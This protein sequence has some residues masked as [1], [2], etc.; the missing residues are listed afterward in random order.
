[1][2]SM[3]PATTI[4]A[5]PALIRSAPRLTALRA[6]P[7]TLLMLSAGTWGGNPALKAACRAGIC[8]SPA[9]TTVPMMTWPTRSCGARERFTT[10]RMTAAPRSIAD[11]AANAP[12]SFPKGVLAPAV[13]T[14][15][16]IFYS[17][18]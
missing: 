16:S 7:Q 4:S 17:S 9:G 11:I 6:E 15:S 3:P 2:L 10:S 1:M 12:P 18:G 13:M 14:T 5:S 8:P